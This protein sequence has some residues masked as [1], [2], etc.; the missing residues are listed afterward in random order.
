MNTDF[1]NVSK[2]PLTGKQ[3]LFWGAGI[4]MVF[5]YFNPS[6][7][8]PVVTVFSGHH[9][10]PKPSPL[11]PQAT[12]PSPDQVSAASAAAMLAQESTEFTG[13]W[14][15]GALVKG[16]GTC[17][18]DL[19]IGTQQDASKPFTAY[20]NMLC[21]NMVPTAG[22]N[23]GPSTYQMLTTLRYAPESTIL[24]GALSDKTIPYR[25]D[26]VVS[27]G[28]DNCSMESMDIT[29]FGSGQV[30]AQWKDQLRRWGDHAGKAIARHQKNIDCLS[31]LERTATFAVFRPSRSADVDDRINN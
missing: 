28:Q 21:I 17:K 1:T 24:S 4:L 25:T 20:T 13:K 27:H 29:P 9:I 10:A 3:K 26:R 15:G 31:G 19:E 14:A 5:L 2:K 11:I 16:R 23:I 30:A 6:I 12:A 7:V 22:T 18:L 8:R